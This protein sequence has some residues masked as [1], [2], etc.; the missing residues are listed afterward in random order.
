MTLL[1]VINMLRTLLT[2]ED[3]GEMM[4]CL[5]TGVAGFIGSHLAERLLADGHDVCGIDAF[6]DFY[7]RTLKEQNLEGPSAFHTFNFIEANLLEIDLSS[8]L[9]GIA[10]VFHLAAQPGVRTSWGQAFSQYVDCNILATQRLLE[11]AR[12][13][14]EI[15]R[16]VYASS[17]SVYGKQQMIPLAETMVPCPL[18]PYGVTKLAGEHLCQVYRHNFGLPIVSLRYFSVYGPRQRPDMAFHRF[19]QAVLAGLPLMIYG[20]VSQARDYTYVVDV[21][22]ATL[23][24]AKREAAIGEVINIA[25]GAAITLQEVIHLLQEISGQSVS[26]SFVTKPY[27]D[28]EHTS[29]DLR[30]AELLLGYRP[31]VAL[32]YGL[33]QEFIAMRKYSGNVEQI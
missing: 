2:S 26:L 28:V 19:C 21:V 6:I 5:V 15:Q 14:K 27:G 9:E 18:S 16:F 8:L 7:P 33:E 3:K 25:G 11:A 10:W 23:S 17:S 12:Q 31:T 1:Y 29:A 4:R 24:A 20:D 22:E 30:K 32:R 13:R